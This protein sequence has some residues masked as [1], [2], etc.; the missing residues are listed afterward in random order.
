[1]AATEYFDVE[2]I[3]AFI[4]GRLRGTERERVVKLLGESEAAFEVYADALRARADLGE[5]DVIPITPALRRRNR[6]WL[7]AIP[8]LAAAA[9]LVAVLPRMRERPSDGLLAMPSELIVRPL[10]AQSTA[11]P[12]IGQS[13]AQPVTRQRELAVALGPTLDEQSWPVTR[14][15]G[16]VLVD[17]AA[18]LRLG[19]RAT[20]LQVALAVEDR[21]R[22]GRTAGEMLDLLG[23]VNLSD[24]SRADY[25]KIRT[26]ITSGDSLGQI[27]ESARRADDSLGALLGSHWFGLGKWFRAGELAARAHSA[28]FFASSETNEFLDVAMQREGL[29]PDDV[30][31]LRDVAG[32]AEG[33]V[34][35]DEFE[36]VQEKFAE[37]IRRHGG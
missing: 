30:G 35:D 2:L 37:L 20:D 22:A 33:G 17:S 11:R 6:P 7:L 25:A 16:P 4:D 13:R 24:A 31:L 34:T 28:P 36:P 3:A 14:G 29:A 9:L 32:L 21:D 26:R 10:L 23:S 12:L 15:G 8:A 5:A 19:V 18:Y 27:A 1:M